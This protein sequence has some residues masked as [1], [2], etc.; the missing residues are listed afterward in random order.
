MEYIGH[1]ERLALRKFKQGDEEFIFNLLNS[2]GW[3]QFIGDR[4]IK[5][6]EDAQG[7]LVNGP[8]LSYNKFGFG[9]YLVELKDSETPI[10]MCSLIKR[11][12]LE[13]VDI[14]FAFLPNFNGKGYA[15]EAASATLNFAQNDL[16]LDRIVAITNTNNT[17]SINLLKK[18]GFIFEKSVKFPDED[19]ELFLFIK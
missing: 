12:T 4:N 15:F 7:Y 16:K 6:I 14:G 19:E 13:H 1:T 3:L 18:L 9:P 11:D 8:L 10:G 2:P 17:S 5:T